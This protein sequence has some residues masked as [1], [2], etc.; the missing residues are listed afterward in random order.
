MK[1]FTTNGQKEIQITTCPRTAQIR[2]KFS[3][4]GE[5]PQDLSGIYTSERQAEHAVNLYLERTKERKKVK[6]E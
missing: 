1:S 6:G 4:G 3:N 2:L 5:L